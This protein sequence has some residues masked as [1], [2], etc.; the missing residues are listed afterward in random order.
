M[1]GIHYLERIQDRSQDDD[2]DFFNSFWFVIV[3]FSTVGYG[4]LTPIGWISKLFVIFTIGL[5]LIF[6]PVQV[7]K[8]FKLNYVTFFCFCAFSPSLIIAIV[9][10]RPTKPQ[11]SKPSPP[12]YFLK[13]VLDN[14]NVKLCIFDTDL[15]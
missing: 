7:C 12:S 1:C 11:R 13:I 15:K 10:R 9:D 8:T 4:D 14:G 6:I 3:T 2:F 5:A